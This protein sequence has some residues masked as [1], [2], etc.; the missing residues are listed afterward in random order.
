M[1]FDTCLTESGVETL[2]LTGKLELS[3]SQKQNLGG[4]LFQGLKLYSWE[5]YPYECHS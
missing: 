2:A 4:R 5:S 1:K 3:F